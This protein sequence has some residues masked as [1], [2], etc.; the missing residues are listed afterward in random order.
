LKALAHHLGGRR[1]G[2]IEGMGG[3]GVQ[4]Y[5]GA[6]RTGGRACGASR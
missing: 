1:C 2:E 4:G 5:H 6:G 3:H